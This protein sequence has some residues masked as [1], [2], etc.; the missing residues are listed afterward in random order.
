VTDKHLSQ[1]ERGNT[2]DTTSKAKIKIEYLKERKE[3][4]FAAP[5]LLVNRL[6]CLHNNLLFVNSTLPGK[7]DVKKMWDK[8]S[9]IDVYDILTKTYVISFYINAIE[10][11]KINDLLATDTHIYA[12]IGTKVVS[13]RLEDV[14]KNYYKN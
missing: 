13:Y 8:A 5:P 1:I 12:L 6:S 7:Y 3:T 4:K 11:E 9:V 10:G 2:I 14:L